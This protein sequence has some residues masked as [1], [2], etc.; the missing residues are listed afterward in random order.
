MKSDRIAQ[1][2]DFLESDPNDSFTRYALALEYSGMGEIQI[3]ISLLLEVINRDSA[4][5]PAYQQ[6]GYQYLKLDRRAE[7]EQ[8]FRRGIEVAREQND[9]HALREMQDALDELT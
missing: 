8:V 7:A 5:V 9:P 3:A 4:Y 1:L 2:K 6:L